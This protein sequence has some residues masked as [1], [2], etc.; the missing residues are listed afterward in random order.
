MIKKKWKPSNFLKK[1][2]L[3]YNLFSE[4]ATL[5]HKFSSVTL[6]RN[7]TVQYSARM[8]AIIACQMEFRYYPMDIQECPI[9]I[10]SCKYFPLFSSFN[11]RQKIIIKI[12]NGSTIK[13][14]QDITCHQSVTDIFGPQTLLYLTLTLNFILVS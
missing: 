8:H 7:K 14:I 12:V 13:R 11:T 3:I 4:I 1:Y 9:Y 2:L 5:T 6:Y 10:E